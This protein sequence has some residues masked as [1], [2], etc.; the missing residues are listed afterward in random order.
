MKRLVLVGGGHAH[1]VVLQG[2]ARRSLSAVEL[3][4]VTPNPAEIYTGMLP[5]VLAGHYTLE[6]AQIDFVA[7][8][9]RAGA[10]FI[11][12]A[13]I[14]LDTSQRKIFLRD[15]SALAYDHAALDVGAITEATI[16]GA[17]EHALPI[18]PFAG[19]LDTLRESSARHVAL[20]GGGAAGVEL[21]MALRHGG[22][23]AT[24]YSGRAS[25]APGLERRVAAALRARGVNR[26]GLPVDRIEADGTVRAGSA[27]ARY[28]LV[29][30]ATGAAAWPWL[31]ETGLATDERGFVLVD[32]MLRSASHP[33]IFATGDCAT[34]R[35]APHPKAGVYAV[36]H[37]EA[38]LGN[39]HRLFAEEPLERF[40]PQRR[41]LMLLS[42]GGKHAIGEYGSLTFEGGWAWRWKHRI[43]R[44]WVRRMANPH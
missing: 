37:G 5:G 26:V 24:V 14:G 41:A 29:I 38:L 20:I 43:D 9:A 11:Q 18:K 21:A 3:T 6:E 44:G 31:R 12:Q 4:V 30:L 32:E 15:G 17:R 2:L 7:L 19:F 35:D 22:A 39:L 25:F 8:A 10:R 42:C 28:D 34:L 13:A 23:E 16:P 36:R 1:A 40:V 27:S 33:E